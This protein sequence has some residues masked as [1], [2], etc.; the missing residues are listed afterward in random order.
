MRLQAE[1]PITRVQTPVGDPA[2]LVTRYA[3]VKA[4]LAD[5][6]FGRSHPDP[7]RA[8]RITN[9][10]VLGAPMHRPEAEAAE[11]ARM[12]RA[13]TPSFMARRMGNLRPAV[14]AI[15]DREVGR[16][17]AMPQPVDLHA[18]LAIPVPA[19][20][21]CELFGVPDEDRQQFRTWSTQAASLSGQESRTG[22]DALLQYLVGFIARKRQNLAEDVVS[23]LIVANDADPEFTQREMITSAI[24]VLFAGHESMIPR[25]DFGTLWL[26][27]SP[28]QRRELQEDPSLIRSAVEELLRIAAAGF[29][30][31]P[32]YAMT[33]VELDGVSIRSGE[34]VLVSRWAAHRDPEVFA[35]AER[36]DLRREGNQ[37]LAFGHGHHFCIGAALAR[38]ELQTLLGTLF[39]RLP[40]LRLAVPMEELRVRDHLTSGGLEALPVVW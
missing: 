9:S 3:D 35:D 26:L 13:L 27:C 31:L 29:D 28:V 23:D 19:L 38:V 4:L 2:W 22:F 8:P 16:V 32:R 20:V 14:Q 5:R 6:R 34:L 10:L 7:E 18:E 11:H 30:V 21:I 39:G 12:R 17:A 15:V 1:R 36:F 33:D 40:S 25:I 37:H 24:A